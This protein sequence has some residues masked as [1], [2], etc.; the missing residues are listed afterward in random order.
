M[1]RQRDWQKRMMAVGR[2]LKCGSATLTRRTRARA[3]GG[4]FLRMCKRCA[5]RHA[6][7]NKRAYENKRRRLTE[8]TETPG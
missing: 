1:S 8:E 4:T 3:S 2:C 7:I 5:R 6:A